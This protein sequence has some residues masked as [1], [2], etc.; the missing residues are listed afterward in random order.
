MKVIKNYKEFI[1]ESK[2]NATEVAKKVESQIYSEY[3]KDFWNLALKSKIFNDE[4]KLFIKEELINTEINLNNLNENFLIKGWNW[5]TNKSSE[6]F[7]WFLDKI[8]SIRKGIS[9]YVRGIKDW[10]VK[11][12]TNL[13]KSLVDTTKNLFSSKEKELEEKLKAEKDQEK[14]SGELFGI[15][16]M[17][18]WWAKSSPEKM[19]QEVDELASKNLSKI[20]SSSEELL[21]ET[22]KEGEEE[23]EKL[24]LDEKEDE[25][26][27]ENEDIL[28]SFHRLQLIKE[29]GKE[30]KSNFQ[31]WMDWIS[32][33][34]GGKEMPEGGFWE[35]AKWWGK[36]FVRIFVQCLSPV[37]L[38]IKGAIKTLGKDALNW[39]S[40]TTSKFGFSPR[41]HVVKNEE[42]KSQRYNIINEGAAFEIKISKLDNSTEYIDLKIISGIT[43]TVLG[44]TADSLASGGY[45]MKAVDGHPEGW[46]YY[47]VSEKSLGG[48]LTGT[49][50]AAA[51]VLASWF[52]GALGWMFENIPEAETI[53]N[54]FKL[55]ISV[56]GAFL[57]YRALYNKLSKLGLFKLA[58]GGK[59]DQKEDEKEDGL[60]GELMK[61]KK[62]KYA[63]QSDI[64]KKL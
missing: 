59:K 11:F 38:A 6:F 53:K 60:Y 30:K 56:F 32:D 52:K 55:V 34:F 31:A 39:L 64:A 58:L 5:L 26:K 17:I 33:F 29:G 62:Q 23:G 42:L 37:T 36:L 3:S 12:I 14:L 10:V 54:V 40:W 41:T 22:E 1:R 24:D 2:K 45:Y 27:S 25:G 49:K 20:E 18:E 21:R 13:Y 19:N 8:K 9:T 28:Y 15:S 63:A 51:K 50:S 16:K 61:K 46:M 47:L 7:N 43:A 48:W 57:M 4:E 35:K 44:L